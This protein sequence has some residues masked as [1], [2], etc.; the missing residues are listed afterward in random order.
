MRRTLLALLPL[1]ALACDDAG[2]PAGP[3]PDGAR[4]DAI[5]DADLRRDASPDAA[6]MPDAKPMADAAPADSA[7]PD[8]GCVPQGREDCNDRDD[9][10]DNRVDEE[11]VRGCWEGPAGTQGRGICRNGEQTCSRGVWGECVGQVLPTREL[12]NR[13][14][15]DCDGDADEDLF[16]A[17]GVAPSGGEGLCRAPQQQCVRGEWGQCGPPVAPVDEVCDGEDNDC[18]GSNDEDFPD[19]D[20]DGEADCVDADRDGDGVANRPDNCA[21][22]ANPDQTDTDGDGR[23][24]ACDTD[25]DDDGVLDDEDCDPL[26]PD[27][28]PG[29]PERCDG[30]DDDCDGVVDEGLV[31]ACYDGWEGTAGVGACRGGRQTCVEGDWGECAGQVL[32]DEEH[33][34]GIDN[35]CDEAVDEGLM[36]GWPDRDG[37]GFG[38]QAT[39]PLCPAPPGLVAVGGDCD[40]ENPAVHPGIADDAPDADVIDANCDGIDGIAE[41]MV[42]VDGQADP[43][44]ADGT[45][46]APFADLPTAIEFAVEQGF[47]GV[48]VSTGGY[49]GRLRLADG[50]SVYGGYRASDGWSRSPVNATLLRNAFP[51]FLRLRPV[52][53]D[54]LVP[55]T[56]LAMVSVMTGDHPA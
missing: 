29:A 25:D 55:P 16:Q 26:D 20:A 53:R 39:P 7:P 19:L 27:R 42:F 41:A 34:D 54:T 30:V 38:D 44:V 12:C 50:V 3:L 14:D 47:S 11:L 37:D 32:P 35:D 1:L 40:D 51:V 22:T 36:P 28:L 2:D 10:C 49:H 9:D 43:D 4:V 33:C 18:D 15:D 21:D 45:R 46:S 52:P 23:G 56:T 13:T 17:C 48:A 31:R 8:A 24:D 5:V 6:A